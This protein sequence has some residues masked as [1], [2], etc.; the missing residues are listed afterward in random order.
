MQF[1]REH[2]PSARRLSARHFRAA[3]HGDSEE[4]SAY[5][6]YFE[7]FNTVSVRMRFE[8]AVPVIGR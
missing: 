2:P 7:Y 8:S 4:P 1:R 5:S 3:R 6:S